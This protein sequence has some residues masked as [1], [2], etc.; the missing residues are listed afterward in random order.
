MKSN[1]GG[2]Y[3]LKKVEKCKKYVQIIDKANK[4]GV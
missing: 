3:E 2:M 1:E 4:D